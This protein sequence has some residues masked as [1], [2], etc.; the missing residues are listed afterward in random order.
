MQGTLRSDV[1]HFLPTGS[2]TSRS[3]DETALFPKQELVKLEAR[4]RAVWS[5]DSMS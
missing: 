5:L 2:R 4:T 1:S 3:S